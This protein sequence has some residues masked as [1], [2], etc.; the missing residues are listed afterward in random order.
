MPMCDRRT[1]LVT[2]AAGLGGWWP[3]PAGASPAFDE[4]LVGLKA[5]ARKRGIP[6]DILDQAFAGVSPLPKVI[7]ADRRQPESRMT[8]I[9]YRDRVVS[10]DRI[11]RGRELL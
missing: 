10:T 8:F 9:E 11:E 3:V 6:R 4:W 2:L 5:E 7:E 1:A